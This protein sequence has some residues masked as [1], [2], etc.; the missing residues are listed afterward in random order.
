MPLSHDG[1]YGFFMGASTADVSSLRASVERARAQLDLIEAG[2]A[3]LTGEDTALITRVR[4]RAA[5]AERGWALAV[6]IAIVVGAAVAGAWLL[7]PRRTPSAPLVAI[8]APAPIALPPPTQA[9]LA[10]ESV[11]ATEAPASV[12]PVAPMVA[13]RPRPAVA[14]RTA[15]LFAELGALTVVCIPKCESTMDNDISLGPG[16]VFNRPVR[17]GR[18]VLRLMSMNGVIKTVTVDVSPE[19]TREVR[20]SMDR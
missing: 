15:P 20:I 18:H 1:R 16:H 4:A 17:A 13:R 9:P 3:R 12:E 8:E 19:Q 7:G 11:A 14:P 2:L 10:P 5:R 6:A